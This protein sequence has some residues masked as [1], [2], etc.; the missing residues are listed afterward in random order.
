MTRFP[1]RSRCRARPWPSCR[2]R[3]HASSSRSSPAGPARPGRVGFDVVVPLLHG[4]Y[5]E[6]GTVQGLFELAGVPYVGSGVVGS[7]VAMD[8]VMMKRAFA[9]CGL[10]TPAHLVPPR[11]SRPR[12]LHAPGRG[13]ARLPVLREARQPRLV[14]RRVAK[15]RDRDE[16]IAAV[17]QAAGFD[18]WILVEE[19]IAGREIE[20]GIL[21]DDPPEASVPG[22]IVPGDDFYTYADKYEHD[23][24][25]A[26]RAR[27]R[28][29]TSRP[30]TVRDL[31]VRGVRGVPVRGDGA[32]RLL[33][34]G[35][36]RRRLARARAS[37][38]TR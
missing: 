9:A 8:K 1:P 12:R 15:A 2:T 29:P 3:R 5:G 37:S 16:L 26:A 33:P 17:E 30:T 27:R 11:R 4:P 31:A 23:D 19:E 20:V 36:A 34:R 35:A 10:P 38:S 6:D 13:G 7:A 28:S 22:E 18:E 32:R 14:G 24:A 21:G 25:A